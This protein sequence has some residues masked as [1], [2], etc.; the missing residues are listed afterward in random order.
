MANGQPPTDA[1]WDRL[2]ALAVHEFRTPVT[3][4]AGYIS[5]LLKD[6]AGPLNEQQRRLL[7]ESAKSTARLSAL[8]AEM[9]D[10]ASIEEGKATFNRATVDFGSVLN[11]AIAAL[12]PVTDREVTIS[13]SNQAVGATVHGDATRLKTA[14]SAVLHALRRELVTSTE[15][16]VRVRREAQNGG[17]ILYIAIADDERVE[18][19]DRST[20]LGRFDEWRGGCGLSLAL[21]RRILDRHDGTIWSPADDPKAGAVIVLPEAGA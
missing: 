13:V 9:S 17:R 18:T 19:V 11:D 16:A 14:L 3:V 6:R 21:A 7:E 4:V 10:L 20:Q 5:M 2:L 1:R 12:A 8:I 15:L